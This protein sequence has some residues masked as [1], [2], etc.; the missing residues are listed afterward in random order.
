MSSL[1]ELLPQIPYPAHFGQL[2]TCRSSLESALC[3]L[4]PYSSGWMRG[5]WG[6]PLVSGGPRMRQSVV[7]NAAPLR[8]L[9]QVCLCHAPSCPAC[10]PAIAARSGSSSTDAPH[11][12]SRLCSVPLPF[13]YWTH[14][15]STLFAP[16]CCHPIGLRSIPD[17]AFQMMAIGMLRRCFSHARHIS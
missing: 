4:P 13:Y 7:V 9:V 8:S 5:L 16:F 1:H 3:G 17:P 11:T 12:T 15:P 6:L 2:M 14:R 10:S